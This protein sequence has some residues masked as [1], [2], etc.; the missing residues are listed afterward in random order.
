MILSSF[1]HKFLRSFQNHFSKN[2]QNH[3]LL[4]VSGGV[5]SMVL[6]H[7]FFKF[8]NLLKCEFRVLTVHHGSINEFRSKSLNV[9]SEFCFKNNIQ[10]IT[11]TKFPDH[12]LKTEEDLRSWRYQNFN[13]FKN[14]NEILVLAHHIDDL[15]ESQLMDLLRGSHF[16]NWEQ[17][18]E[19]SNHTYRP[20]AYVTKT[21][22]LEYANLNHL[23]WIE[24]PT[25]HET[26]TLRNWL[27]NTF[28][29]DLSTQFPG[30]KENL[31]KNLNRLYEHQP[32][33]TE[34]GE[35]EVSTSD[36]LLFSNAQKKQFV[37]NSAL[38]LGLKSMTQG[39]ILDTV[40]KLDLGQKDIKF[41]VGPLF[42][43]KTA[44]RLL[45]YRRSHEE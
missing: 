35:L 6:L 5:D 25:N 21:E 26:K 38:R 22:I 15:L 20:L 13:E 8:K 45:A 28:L 44:D 29:N 12:D 16:Q 43:T 39:Q 23:I 34:V 19:F 3:F 9:V 17:N 2:I 1:E 18:K 30:L 42:W 31:M 14:Q 11:N 40:K 7:L 27:R 36:W 10:F 4:C 33:Q 32:Q 41:R 24:D 37:L